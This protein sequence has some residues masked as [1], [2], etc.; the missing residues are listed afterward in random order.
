MVYSSGCVEVVA[1][2]LANFG[3]ESI[4]LACDAKCGDLFKV[5]M[6]ICFLPGETATVN[7]RTEIGRTSP[8]PLTY[9]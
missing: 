8:A 5:V 1:G 6:H 9:R 7:N 2:S 4:N 3:V